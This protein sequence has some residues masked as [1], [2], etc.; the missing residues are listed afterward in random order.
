M[1]HHGG[2]IP[3]QNGA[4]IHALVPKY[5]KPSFEQHLFNELASLTHFLRG[6]SD[7]KALMFF[8]MTIS[9][10]ESESEH[11]SE[12]KSEDDIE[13][14]AGLRATRLKPCS[15][16]LTGLEELAVRSSSGEM[17][18]W[19]LHLVER[20]PP[21]KL[22]S[23]SF[24]KFMYPESEPCSIAA[25]KKDLAIQRPLP[26]K[27]SCGTVGQLGGNQSLGIF[28]R[29]PTFP[30]LQSL[31]IWLGPNREAERLVETF[32]AAPNL[33]TIIFRIGL[34]ENEENCDHFPL[35]QRIGFHF[36]APRESDMH[37]RCG[38]L[39]KDAGGCGGT[40]RMEWLD[41]DYNPVTYSKKSGKPLQ[42]WNV[43]RHSSHREPETQ[44]SDCDWDSDSD[45]SIFYWFNIIDVPHE[46]H[47]QP[48]QA[49]I[50][51]WLG[52]C[53]LWQKSVESHNFSGYP[54]GFSISWAPLG[55]KS[56]PRPPRSIL[57]FEYIW[58]G[59]QEIPGGCISSEITPDLATL[60]TD[61]FMCRS[62][63]RAS[64]GINQL[65]RKTARRL[66]GVI[67]VILPTCTLPRAKAPEQHQRLR[68]VGPPEFLDERGGRYQKILAAQHLA[69]EGHVGFERRA[70]AL[71]KCTEEAEIDVGVAHER[72]A[73]GCGFVIQGSESSTSKWRYWTPS[74][75]QGWPK[76][77]PPGIMRDASMMR[78]AEQMS[79]ARIQTK[80]Q[81]GW[82]SKN[83]PMVDV[84]AM[85]KSAN[86]KVEH[87]HLEHLV[88]KLDELANSL[89]EWRMR[90]P[91]YARQDHKCARGVIIPR[92]QLEHRNGVVVGARLVSE[93]L[94]R[95]GLL[96]DRFD[97]LQNDLRAIC[98]PDSGWR[99]EPRPA[100]FKLLVLLIRIGDDSERAVGRT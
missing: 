86:H 14:S 57:S 60:R 26:H 15:F 100:V 81:R 19:L 79:L 38:M 71:G 45:G 53:R 58:P 35:I 4:R 8:K 74:F 96:R 90:N 83:E 59:S 50:I 93:E 5:R 94:G 46:H 84:F 95:D 91:S 65:V 49:T 24:D 22:K 10:S 67:P 11:E 6:C 1:G 31:T 17:G 30:S 27:S 37:F 21:T 9:E 43:F 68:S 88:Y 3:P 76:W 13:M 52:H 61:E 33:S 78:F 20:S 29:L 44:A 23:L 7:L 66:T 32:P 16:N 92:D 64:A 42:P 99:R 55:W 28:S 72:G 82:W 70:C 34:E 77:T 18:E 73:G 39:E 98:D 25:M 41:G 80:V 51:R 40:S 62:G 75:V 47:S 2:G 12:F 56:G 89:D 85:P 48:T 54:R 87:V 69:D 97:H 63:L 36:C